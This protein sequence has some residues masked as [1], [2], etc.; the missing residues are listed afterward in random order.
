MFRGNRRSAMKVRS[1]IVQRKNRSARTPHYLHDEMPTLVIDRRRPG[2]GHHHVA[3]KDDVRRFLGILPEWRELSVGL[4]A[5][6]LDSGFLDCMGW[7]RPGVVAI[8]AWDADFVWHDCLPAFYAEHAAIIEKL[9]VPVCRVDDRIEVQFT[10]ATARAFLLVH[11]LVHELGHHHDRM[12]T[13]SKRN[14]AS[15]EGYAEA[16]ARR[17]EDEIL[18]RYHRR[19]R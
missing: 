17:H 4:N 16:Y 14:T 5:V 10:E 3:S 7:H 15:G 2:R 6:V 11:V 9:N 12:A 19:F 1:G 13:R 18:S 8:C